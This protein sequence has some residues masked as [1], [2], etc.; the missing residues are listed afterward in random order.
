M[1][2][3][4]NHFHNSSESKPIIPLENVRIATPCHA[5][6]NRMQ[7]DDSVRF[8][9]SCAKN[10]YNLSAMSK[11]E[12]E[13]LIAEKEGNLCA[14]YYQRADGNIIT[15]NCP[16]GI[17]KLRRPF[18]W[19]L[20]GFAAL[21]ALVNVATAKETAKQTTPPKPAKKVQTMRMGVVCIPPPKTKPKAKPTPK[22]KAKTKTKTK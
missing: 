8:C 10:V 2:Q 9:Q 19:L 20:A 21:L 1:K 18:G 12:A 14:R 5:D 3:Q 16:V 13:S 17:Q 7:G 6:W 15:D 22:P 11:A 4:T